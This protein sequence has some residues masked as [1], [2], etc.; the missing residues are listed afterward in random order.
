MHEA[1][2]RPDPLVRRRGLCR[3]PVPRRAVDPVVRACQR[4][5]SYL[6]VSRD[7]SDATRDP[8]P[9]TDAQ[10]VAAAA[11]AGIRA[12]TVN[13]T[14][15]TDWDT[16]FEAVAAGEVDVLLISPERLNPR[17]GGATSRLQPQTPA[18]RPPA[19]TP[20]PDSSGRRERQ[21]PLPPTLIGPAPAAPERVLVHTCRAA[22]TPRPGEY[23]AV[24]PPGERWS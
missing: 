16:I 17:P 12:E 23:T 15:L 8:R 6:R 20:P 13:F 7:C 18:G 5:A 14:N 4:A 19:A 11:W 2:E 9:A 24:V 21:Q 10:P 22:T 1:T 3:T